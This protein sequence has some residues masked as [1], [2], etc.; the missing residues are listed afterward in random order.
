MTTAPAPAT[1]PLL[2]GADARYPFAALLEAAE[3][4]FVAAGL[5]PDK[6]SSV[7]RALV[8]AD[9]MGHTTHGLALVPWY[10]D[11]LAAG[12]MER[13]GTMEVLSDRGSCVAWNGRRLPGAWLIER[14][15]DLALERIETHGVVTLT[16]A[17]AHHTGALAVYLPRVTERGLMPILTCSSPAAAG[18]APFGGTR[19]LLTPNPIGAGIPT[20]GDP[21]LLDISASITTSNR[22]RQLAQAGERFPADWV[23]DAAGQATNDPAVA[24]SGGGT[25]LPVGGLDHGHKGFGLALLVEALTQGLSG[26]GRRSKPSGILTNIFVQVIDPDAFGGREGFIAESGWLGEACRANPPRPG[27]ERVRLPGEHAM[28]SLRHARADGVPLRPAILDGLAPHLARLGVDWP[29]PL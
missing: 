2:V 24:V 15:F 11:A 21:V 3:A 27:V 22:A 28:A 23:M 29:A 26:L 17:G 19:G 4:L 10:L 8:Q 5:P 18:V 6:A 13:Q 9:A 12:Q 1:A 25:L 16:I 20:P 14:A 7:A